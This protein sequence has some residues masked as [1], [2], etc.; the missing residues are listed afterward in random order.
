MVFFSFCLYVFLKGYIKHT[1]RI[2]GFSIIKSQSKN[3]QSVY[4]RATGAPKLLMK[5]LF[6]KNVNPKL[7]LDLSARGIKLAILQL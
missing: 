5:E 6:K 1:K 3:L 2:K 4:M 7:P